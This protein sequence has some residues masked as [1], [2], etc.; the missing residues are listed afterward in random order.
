MRI[1]N[2]DP[3][4]W[5]TIS[6]H[7]GERTIHFT[8]AYPVRVIEKREHVCVHNLGDVE[9]TAERRSFTIETNDEIGTDWEAIAIAPNL[10]SAIA[11]ATAMIMLG[12]FEGRVMA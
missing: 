3:I 2:E 11:N 8:P 12:A 5:A 7:T 10:R 4:M 6:D 1:E 9:V